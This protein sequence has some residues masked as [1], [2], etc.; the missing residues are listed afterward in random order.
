MV[1][2]YG[3]DMFS[4]PKMLREMDGSRLDTFRS[5]YGQQLAV[6]M[7]HV[8]ELRE[9]EQES[10]L[11]SWSGPFE[12]EMVPQLP[13][14]EDA[15]AL[16]SGAACGR[17][18]PFAVIRSLA[19]LVALRRGEFSLLRE[20]G[21]MLGS[22]DIGL[23]AALQLSNW[24]VAGNTYLE[25]LRYPVIEGLR[26]ATPQ[27]LLVQLSRAYIGDSEAAPPAA[28]SL[29]SDDAEVA[30]LGALL[31]GNEPVLVR[32]VASANP[33]QWMVAA[34]KLIELKRSEL[35]VDVFVRRAD[36][37]QQQDLLSSIS[38]AKAPVSAL[39]AAL[40]DVAGR[41]C[42][43]R[44]GRMAATAICLSC[45]HAEAMQLAELLNWEMLHALSLSKAVQPETFRAIG[46]LLV[47]EDKV[48]MSQYAWSC[49]ATPGR[50]PED[51][52]ERV[53]SWARKRETEIELLRFAEK[54]LD[55][56][57]GQPRGTAMERV[58]IGAAFGDYSA[59]VIGEAWAAMHRINYH[60]EYGSPSPFSYS[61]ENVV[62]FWPLPEFEQRVAR[63]Q[64]NQ[65][66]MNEIFVADD[67]RR[68]LD[69]RPRPPVPVDQQV[70]PP[71]E[72]E[73]AAVPV[74]EVP[75]EKALHFD[76]PPWFK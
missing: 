9:L 52:V 5:I 49:M 22:P 15:M 56:L 19:C 76:F 36:P 62:A 27:T 66:A 57:V 51:F 12:E 37:D 39:H 32:A 14:R 75:S 68:F 18:S 10:F 67:L 65:D 41:H 13:W 3:A 43:T 2:F 8:E 24:R 1:K 25:G 42:G 34:K 60:R 71:V 54:Q 69:T 23:E 40:F 6:V 53:F 38:S 31:L 4:I 30:F 21:S 45:S 55:L 72:P 46:E 44:L 11:K 50:M 64:A 70:L 74:Q 26:R 47:R 73:P 59:P 33:L 16:Y 7:R 58:L 48:R 17:Q 20:V 35:V 29:T 63:L 28:E 61:V